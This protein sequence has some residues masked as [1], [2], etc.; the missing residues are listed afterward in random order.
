LRDESDAAQRIPVGARTENVQ[1]R[2][3]RPRG[4]LATRQFERNFIV[5]QLFKLLTRPKSLIFPALLIAL[6]VGASKL[7]VVKT[8]LV[9]L[10][11]PGL[12]AQV[13]GLLPPELQS[14]AAAL[15]GAV[16][17]IPAGVGAR[18]GEFS[19]LALRKALKTTVGV[20]DR[21]DTP[22]TPPP[23]GEL[24]LVR[25]TAPLGQNVAYVSPVKSGAKRPAIIWIAGGFTFNVDEAA[26]LPAP[27]E[28]DQ[29]ARQ[30][31]Q[32]GIA[33][34]YAALRGT[35]QNPG[36][37]ECF[38][39]EVDDILA[40][41]EFLASREDV[42]PK[43]IYLGGHSTGGTMA[44]LAAEST[45]RFRAVFAFGPVADLRQYGEHGCLPANAPDAEALPRRPW[46]FLREIV[47]PTF[48]IEGMTSGNGGAFTLFRQYGGGAPIE[49]V[50]VEAADHFT[51]LAPGLEVVARA[52]LADSGEKPALEIDAAAI[53]AAL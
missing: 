13:I 21:D 10:L 45:A 2:L 28:N 8:R 26:W 50:P 51:V 6:A 37:K 16:A 7:D 42:D 18:P 22:P 43:R 38:L 44:L 25:Y 48:I 47:S 17:G 12:K 36:H 5:E 20:G 29:S 15:E 3:L 40:A 27:R 35:S 14:K 49:L 1:L 31:R 52:I 34:M 41:A 39:G 19:V 53:A 9:A 46:V 30:L 24:E 33:T 23:A 32:A 4:A 11:P